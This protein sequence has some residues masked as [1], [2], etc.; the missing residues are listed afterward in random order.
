MSQQLET[1]NLHLRNQLAELLT[2]AQQNQQTL[3]RYQAFDLQFIAATSFRDLIDTILHGFANAAGL[4]S[5][6][7]ALLDPDHEIRRTLMALHIDL[8]EFPQLLFV[9]DNAEL[10]F[11]FLPLSGPTL[12]TYAAHLHRPMFPLS[13]VPVLT[14]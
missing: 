8:T 4:H 14:Q 3:Q 10:S 1:E 5:V 9:Q 7:L 11:P 2:L 13:A 6:T 12:G